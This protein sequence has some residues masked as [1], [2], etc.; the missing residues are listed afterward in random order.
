MLTTLDKNLEIKKDIEKLKEKI[1][2]KEGYILFPEEV[3]MPMRSTIEYRN[4]ISHRSEG[5]M[6]NFEVSLSMIGVIHL[7]V[8][9]EYIKKPLNIADIPKGKILQ[10]LMSESRTQSQQAA[11]YVSS[12]LMTN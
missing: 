11:G 6:R 7:M 4:K 3:L 8:W 1:L 10:D 5:E 9:W 2:S 12:K